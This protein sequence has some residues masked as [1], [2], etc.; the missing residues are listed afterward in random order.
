M[1]LTLVASGGVADYADTSGL[2]QQIASVAGVSPGA[3]AITV[4]AASVLITATIAAEEDV[5]VA[6]ISAALSSSLP[7]AAAAS[8]LLGITIQADPTIHVA[9]APPA[10]PASSPAPVPAATPEPPPVDAPPASPDLDAGADVPA[11][12]DPTGAIIGGASW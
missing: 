1:T 10:S 4:E 5:T 11:A 9:G 3:V 8:T 2:Q 6:S 7:T 12:D